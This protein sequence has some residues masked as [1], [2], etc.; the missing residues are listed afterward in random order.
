MAVTVIRVAVVVA[1][2]CGSRVADD[3][4]GS[5]RSIIVEAAGL[6]GVIVIARSHNSKEMTTKAAVWGDSHGLRRR[7][8]EDNRDHNRDGGDGDDSGDG[9]SHHD[10]K[11]AKGGGGGDDEAMKA[12]AAAATTMETRTRMTMTQST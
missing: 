2:I 8:D 11:G 1:T 4:G 7:R 3:V 5:L 12:A 10:N 9:R 6:S